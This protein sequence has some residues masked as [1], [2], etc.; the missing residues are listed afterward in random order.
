MNC[1]TSHRIC[2]SILSCLPQ[3]RALLSCQEARLFLVPNPAVL[4]IWLPFTFHV[5]CLEQCQRK[6]VVHPT[7]DFSEFPSVYNF[8]GLTDVC[9][10]RWD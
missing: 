2:Y 3:A 9:G 7:V 6:P 4:F 8:A 1:L 5:M 10:S